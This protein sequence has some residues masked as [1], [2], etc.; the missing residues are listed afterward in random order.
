LTD[1]L[2]SNVWTNDGYEV[3]GTNFVD[4]LDY[5]SNRVSTTIND[6]QFIKLIIEQL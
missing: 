3:F 1:D 2:V 4:T 6:Q 5:V